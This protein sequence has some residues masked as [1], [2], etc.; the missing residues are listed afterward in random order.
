MGQ[1]FNVR[2]LNPD[3]TYASRVGEIVYTDSS[4]T[5][6]AAL[7]A[8]SPVGTITSGALPT[9]TLTSTTGAQ[10]ST[11]R[12]VNLY[13]LLTADAT[14]NIASCKIELSADNVTYTELSTVSLAAAVN[15][16][17]A[18]A[19]LAT[20]RVPAGWYVKLTTSHMTIGAAGV[21]S[22]A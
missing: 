14:N 22:Y 8:T 16:T 19:Q 18:V 1:T 17:G 3:G 6:P 7:N 12:D 4:A 21:C 20:V 2:I 9:V 11:A 13:A 5:T 15:N 10:V